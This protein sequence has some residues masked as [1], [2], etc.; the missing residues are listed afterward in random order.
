M[1]GIKYVCGI[2]HLV[3]VLW[4][5]PIENHSPI[6]RAVSGIEPGSV[7][8]K[9][10]RAVWPHE[11]FSRDDIDHQD[12]QRGFVSLQVWPVSRQYF[13]VD[14]TTLLFHKGLVRVVAPG[15]SHDPYFA[16]YAHELIEASTW[17]ATGQVQLFTP[18]IKA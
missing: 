12:V 9:T 3:D 15:L 16:G 2:F 10:Y 1:S 4:R 7:I 5:D 11:R 14:A 13:H 18:W 6:V 8:E 17:V